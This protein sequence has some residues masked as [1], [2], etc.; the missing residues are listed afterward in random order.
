M[1]TL[2]FSSF[3]SSTSTR[4]Y[5]YLTNQDILSLPGFEDKSVIVIKAPPG[6]VLKVP[7]PFDVSA[8]DILTSH[9]SA[10]SVPSSIMLI[11]P[12]PFSFIFSRAYQQMKVATKS[13]FI[14]QM[15]EQLIFSFSI[16]LH[17]MPKDNNHQTPLC[18][19]VKGWG[20]WVAWV[21]TQDFFGSLLQEKPSIISQICF[22]P[23][24]FLMF[25][26]MNS[27]KYQDETKELF[28]FFLFVFTTFH[29]GK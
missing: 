7:D 14:A 17:N 3:P 8:L 20:V 22:N 28:F 23:K 10:A 1:I 5:A 12:L 24:V 25:M 29:S 13:Y 16:L 21:V 11:F 6:T 26:T 18:H 2:T 9:F 15:G 19:Q 4:R 27:K